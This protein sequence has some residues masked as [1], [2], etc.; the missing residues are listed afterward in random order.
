MKQRIIIYHGQCPDGFGAAWAAWRRFGDTDTEYYAH[1]AGDDPLPVERLDGRD[2]LLL[3]MSY[4]RADTERL[5]QHCMSWRVLDHHMTNAETLGDLPY[6]TFDMTRSGAGLAWDE[7]VREPRP[8]L[9]NYIEDR[10]LWRWQYQ[11]SKA[12]LY[13][14][15]TYP[16]TFAAY[17]ALLADDTAHD[18]LFVEG[19]AIERFV[20]TQVRD[21]VARR[22]SITLGGHKIPAV[23]SSLLQ[24]EIGNELIGGKKP[25]PFAAVWFERRDGL[26]KYSLRSCDAGVDVG[27]I[28]LRYGGGGHRNSAGFVWDGEPPPQL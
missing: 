20:T 5:F 2:V 15:D 22:R 11:R 7:L 16:K 8:W 3:D 6:C 24:S 14:L 19:T 13:A 18:R 26:R 4:R 28:A 1:Q 17:D 23:C 12:V 21:A 27:H 10:D 25:P 9:I